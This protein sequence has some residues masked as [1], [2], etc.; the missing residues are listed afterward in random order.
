VRLWIGPW[1]A[2]AQQQWVQPLQEQPSRQQVQ[3]RLKRS[4]RWRLHQL[5]L[6]LVLRRRPIFSFQVV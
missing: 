2:A 6:N 4:R 1:L 3:P 5:R